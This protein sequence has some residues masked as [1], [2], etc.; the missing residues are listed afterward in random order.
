MASK[1]VDI[2]DKAKQDAKRQNE[3]VKKQ[4][5]RTR[6][7]SIFGGPIALIKII[8]FAMTVY[9]LFQYVPAFVNVKKAITQ[10]K[11][12]PGAQ[13]Q[14]DNRNSWGIFTPLRDFTKIKK[15]YVRSGKTLQVQYSMPESAQ[16]KLVIKRCKPIIFIEVF[17]CQVTQTQEID[18]SNET[19]GTHRIHV[20]D[21]AMYLLQ[22]QVEV[23]SGEDY[24]ITWRRS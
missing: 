14:V 23:K 7:D 12:Y 16:A 5:L 20:K 19:V 10:I 11:T 8:L 21:S 22:S 9:A 2:W 4:K 18:I 6:A 15:A 24:N 13:T 17:H 3:N 1:T